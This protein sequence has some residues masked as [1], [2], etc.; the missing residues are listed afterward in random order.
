[1]FGI[2]NLTISFVVMCISAQLQSTLTNT[3]R[4]NKHLERLKETMKRKTARTHGV[5]PMTLHPCRR[6]R[7]RQAMLICRRSKRVWQ[8]IWLYWVSYGSF[9]LVEHLVQQ[10]SITWWNEILTNKLC[11]VHISA[12]CNFS[13]EMCRHTWI[14]SFVHGTRQQQSCHKHSRYVAA[15]SE[16]ATALASRCTCWYRSLG[17]NFSFLVFV[18]PYNYPGKDQANIRKRP[19][20]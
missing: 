9:F 6:R 13:W 14:D 4:P 7:T 18:L 15:G 10:A 12:D 3:Q 8:Q 5:M 20:S 19:L 2:S 16:T 17:Y 11:G 1:M